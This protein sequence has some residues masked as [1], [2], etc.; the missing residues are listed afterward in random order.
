MGINPIHLIGVRI[1]KI[2]HIPYRIHKIDKKS[3]IA[4]G[5]FSL[6]NSN[7]IGPEKIIPKNSIATINAKLAIR[8]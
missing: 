6:F 7:K 3:R 8:Y 5:S 1:T 2:H 4:L